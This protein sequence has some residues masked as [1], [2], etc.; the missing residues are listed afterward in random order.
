MADAAFCAQLSFGPP[1]ASVTALIELRKFLDAFKKQQPTLGALG[2][3]KVKPCTILPDRGASG[4][5]E[6]RQE[7]SD[8]STAKG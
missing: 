7:V 8:D 4:E 2:E 1:M 6:S 5:G 3:R